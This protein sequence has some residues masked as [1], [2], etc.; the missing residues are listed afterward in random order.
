MRC[1]YIR[2]AKKVL[3]VLERVDFPFYFSR[4]SKRTYPLRQHV[5][6]VVRQLV[7]KSY[8]SFT[9]ILKDLNRLTDFF[10]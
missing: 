3:Q 8:Y 7:G 2:V 5:V 4:F 9:E 1:F 6:L 10:F